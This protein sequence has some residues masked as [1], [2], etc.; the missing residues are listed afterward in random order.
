MPIKLGHI[1]LFVQDPARSREFY[2]DM[3]E[4]EVIAEQGGGSF[5]WL[6]SG[7]REILLR[8]ATSPPKPESYQQSGIAFVM[9]TDDLAAT[10]S[11]LKSRGLV[12]RGEDGGA[13]CPTFVDPDGHWFQVV[14][15]ED[16]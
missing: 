12:P 4:F 13:K 5:I 6:K 10:L 2:L 3:L 7:D 14:N 8:R 11:K 15:P 1:E 9:Y 16:H